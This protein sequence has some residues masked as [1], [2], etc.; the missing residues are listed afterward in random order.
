MQPSYKGATMLGSASALCFWIVQ[1][2]I[3]Y[4]FITTSRAVKA[5]K[6]KPFNTSKSIEEN[7]NGAKEDT[8]G[9]V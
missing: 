5:S 6:P 8:K 3:A 1:G 4:I 7:R 2:S 9:A